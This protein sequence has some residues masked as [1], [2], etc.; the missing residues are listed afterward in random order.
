MKIINVSVIEDD[1]VIQSS[2]V[3]SLDMNPHMKCDFAVNSV[4][5]GLEELS[6]LY[7]RKPDVLILD[8]GLPGMT[9]LQGIRHLKKSAP[10]MDI[11]IL[12]TYDDSDKIFEALCSGACS[13]IFKKTSLKAIMEAV[14][15]VHG[16]GSYMSPS[17]ARK[18]A[19]HFIP[20][21]TSNSL[22]E[23]LTKRQLEIVK[24][25]ADGLSYKLIA[26]KYGISLDTVRSH[27]KTIYKTL[28]VNSKIEVVNLYNQK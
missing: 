10:D 4:E 17:I 12:T 28:E 25:L 24:S 8:I 18:I 6:L 23:I 14:I 15:T 19:N 11:I 1:P 3:Q 22:V 13:Y 26:G 7:D 16:G 5:K 9:G 21:E 27:I 2:L 20:K